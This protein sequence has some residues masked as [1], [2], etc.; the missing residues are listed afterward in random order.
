M[1]TVII[2]ADD[3]SLLGNSARAYVDVV[4]K[5]VTIGITHTTHTDDGDY[6]NAWNVHLDTETARTWARAIVA[7]LGDQD[8]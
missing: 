6:E 8:Q 4:H 5:L 2:E 1:S 3:C 7:A